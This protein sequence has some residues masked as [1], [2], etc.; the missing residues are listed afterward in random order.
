MRN[1]WQECCNLRVSPVT[2]TFADTYSLQTISSPNFSSTF[3]KTSSTF[4]SKN[5]LFESL[6]KELFQWL[7]IRLRENKFRFRKIFFS[8][9]V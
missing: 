8:E 7:K 9:G 2:L 5:Y 1:G 3:S 6:F 4:V